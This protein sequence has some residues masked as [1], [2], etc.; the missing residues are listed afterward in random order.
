MTLFLLIGF[1]VLFL[2]ALLFRAILNGFKN[3]EQKHNQTPAD[4]GIPFTEIS[5][6]ANNNCNLYGWWIAGKPSKPLVILVHGW[7]R[8]VG[9]MLPYIANLSSPGFNLIA[10]DSRNHGSSDK[11]SFSSMLKFAEDIHSVIQFA[12]ANYTFSSVC[13][14]GLSIGGAASI[15]AAAF[16]SRIKKVITV[17][18]F[19]NPAAVMTKQLK[20][21]RIPYFP[22][23]WL[24]LKYLEKLI[25]KK[26]DE[27]AP[28]QNISNCRAEILLIHGDKDQTVPVLQATLL[29]QAAMP[30][31]S[32]LWIIR[33]RGHSDCHEETDYWEKVLNFLNKN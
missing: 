7:G 33:G 6:P 1:A 4:Y 19:A 21:R 10:F 14:V 17:G 3:P 11:D 31:S 26:F 18:A 28:V 13:L 24:L 16:D 25:G 22:F 2:S 29:N 30:G 12:Y 5:I 8:N 32:T 15:Y 23:T 27:I 9:R 20:D